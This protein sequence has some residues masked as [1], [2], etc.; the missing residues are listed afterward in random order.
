M[1]HNLKELTK[2]QHRNAERSKF[3][4][5]L[6][7]RQISPEQYYVYLSNQLFMYWVLESMAD[8]LGLFEN[9][10]GIQR[11]SSITIDIKELENDHGFETPSYL[12]STL[13]YVDHIRSISTDRDK[14]LAHIYVRHMGDLSGGQIIKR[15]VPGSAMFYDFDADVNMLKQNLHEML[16]DS[17]EEEAK[18]CFNFVHDFFEELEDSF[19]DMGQAVEPVETNYRDI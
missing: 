16:H 6:L 14:I 7:K 13:R 10:Y 15:Y 11:A 9:L 4:S 8:R 19:Y 18:V 5:R 17:L 2:E 1:K 12:K 3:V